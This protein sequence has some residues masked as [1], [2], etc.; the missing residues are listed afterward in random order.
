VILGSF[1]FKL[2]PVAALWSLFQASAGEGLVLPSDGLVS[3]PALAPSLPLDKCNH[4]IFDTAVREQ[5]ELAL[6]KLRYVQKSEE[7]SAAQ[8]WA[9]HWLE[10]E[11]D[12]WFFRRGIDDH[13]LREEL[14]HDTFLETLKFIKRQQRQDAPPRKMLPAVYT[15]AK[16]LLWKAWRERIAVPSGGL[17]WIRDSQGESRA[18]GSRHVPMGSH[19]AT[20]GNSP[21]GGSSVGNTAFATSFA[22]PTA[23]LENYPSTTGT[24][25]PLSTRQL[26]VLRGLAIGDTHG[27]IAEA[28]GLALKHV[29][30]AVGSV[31][32]KLQ[33]QL[34]APELR[35]SRLSYIADLSAQNR[36]FILYTKQGTTQ[37]ILAEGPL[38]FEAFERQFLVRMVGGRSLL[39]IQT[40]MGLEANEARR[41]YLRLLHERRR[42]FDELFEKRKSIFAA[43]FEISLSPAQLEYAL[44]RAYG[45]ER[46]EIAE[47]TEKDARSISA[48]V[49]K[50]AT[51][52]KLWAKANKIN[53][54]AF[55]PYYC[56]VGESLDEVRLIVLD[57]NNNHYLV[58]GVASAGGNR[59]RNPVFVSRDIITAAI[60]RL[61]EPVR[62][63]L[64]MKVIE[65]L[66]TD[67]IAT[68]LNVRLDTV[69]HHY[70]NGA[71]YLGLA[72]QRPEL[73]L[74]NLTLVD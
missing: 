67:T 14:F 39:E 9:Y 13:Q 69:R 45:L 37:V 19:H 40:D 61:D 58:R 43:E 21:L 46:Y 50:I 26:S 34:D 59:I 29:H 30:D 1:V 32:K 22:L 38:P 56:A 3:R 48:Q 47:A 33:D 52:L 17:E 42:D 31:E 36:V 12:R 54:S 73:N 41:I 63:I 10:K 44:L 55:K 2:L 65:G 7:E 72:T 15:I 16:R 4:F 18:L 71:F 8:G 11:L 28:L 68:R 57:Q 35:R 27:E 23:T 60:H 24:P 64:Q 51:K 6:Q 62:T 20:P 53:L 25:L 70:A 74:I 66:S 5:S 49:E